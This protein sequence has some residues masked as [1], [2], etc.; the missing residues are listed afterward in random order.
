MA[1]F[2][3]L[4]K[5]A[6]DLAPDTPN[7]VKDI[8]LYT[9]PIFDEGKRERLNQK[10]IDHYF[11]REIGFE[12]LSIFRHKMSIKMNEIMP[13]YNQ[14]YQSELIEFDQF[15]TTDMTTDDVRSMLQDIETGSSTHSEADQTENT[16]THSDQTTDRDV[17]ST[18]TSHNESLTD[19]Q[20]R[21]VASQT[22]Q[23]MLSGDGD[24]AT[25][26]TDSKGINNTTADGTENVV[27]AED[28][29]VT[30]DATEDRTA[31]TTGDETTTG[32]SDMSQSGEGTST[33]KGYQG[34]PSSLIM[35]LRDSFL[36]IDMEVINEL[37]E[38]FMG[39]F[40]NGESVYPPRYRDFFG[41]PFGFTGGS[42]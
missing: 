30:T 12:S 24:Y 2:T 28:T 32:T 5:D 42:Y 29:E 27:T 8:G 10:I 3:M 4:L 38:L 33:T 31:N 39:V 11:Y 23:T 37:D 9:Y 25:S 40:T 35:S 34:V 18:S 26:A 15:V 20:S 41:T 1:T 13:L 6:I 7:G 36:N 17:D 14:R 22:P 16:V 21:A 19:N